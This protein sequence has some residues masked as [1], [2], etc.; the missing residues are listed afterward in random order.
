MG[1]KTDYVNA[2]FDNAKA[3]I[4]ALYEEIL[5]NASGSETPVFLRQYGSE[6]IFNMLFCI[7]KKQKTYL[8]IYT[9]FGVRTSRFWAFNV[10]G[11]PEWAKSPRNYDN[12]VGGNQVRYYPDGDPGVG[13][14]QLI[15]NVGEEVTAFV[16]VIEDEW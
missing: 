5:R 2:Q 3:K 6:S 16:N 14:W 15:V 8:R 11:L 7:Y 1:R 9:T 13:G 10:V 12:S 4:D